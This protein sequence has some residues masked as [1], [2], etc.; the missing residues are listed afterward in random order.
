M[1]PS[2]LIPACAKTGDDDK[3]AKSA[4]AKSGIPTSR[5]LQLLLR[6]AFLPQLHVAACRAGVFCRSDPPVALNRR[7]ATRKSFV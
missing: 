3:P 1:L 2:G 5:A 4:A 6:M 7:R